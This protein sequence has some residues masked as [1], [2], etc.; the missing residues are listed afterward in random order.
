MEL[1]DLIK[2]IILGFVEGMTEFAPVSS[3]AYDYCR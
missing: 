2:A 1:F 3:R